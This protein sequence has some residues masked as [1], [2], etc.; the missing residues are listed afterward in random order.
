MAAEGVHLC[1]RAN[2]SGVTE[3]VGKLASGET[4]TRCRFH[5]NNLIIS[6][7]AKFLAYKRAYESS[8]VGTA[9]STAYDDIRLNPYLIQRS[10]GLQTDNRLMQ[11]HL[12]QHGAEHIAIARLGDCSLHGL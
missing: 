7:S 6:L 9:A 8:Q 3:I 4:W 2:H 11:K 12:V 1:Q 5:S 10:L